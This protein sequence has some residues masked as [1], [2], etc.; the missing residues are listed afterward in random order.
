MSYRN[1]S[2]I[3]KSRLAPPISILV[4]AHNEATSIVSSVK[5]LLRLN[6]PAFEVIVVNDGSRD[7][8]L[9]KLIAVFELRKTKR[10]YHQT[11]ATKEVRGI[12]VAKLSSPW[13]RLVVLDK[14]NGGKADALN[15]GINVSEY[16]L[17]CS[18]DADSILERDSLLRVALPFMERAD[19]VG[20][21]GIVR[22]ANG[23]SITQGFVQTV[24]LP[25]QWLP[26]FQA[27]EYLRAFL[28]GRI[29]WA[30]LGS[31]L[32]LSGAFSLFKKAT[33]LEVNGYDRSTVSED[34]ELVMRLHRTLG[35]QGRACYIEFIPDPVCWTE[36]PERFK[37]LWR[38]RDRWQRGS[39][40]SLWKHLP[41]LCNPRFGIL[42]LLATPYF[43][44]VEF[45]S[46]VV[47][48]LGYLVFSIAAIAGLSQWK[49]F[50]AFFLLA[51]MMGVNLSLLAVVLE[52]F[53]LHRYPRVRDL[54]RLLISAV[55]ENFGYRQFTA[56]ARFA[57]ILGF[58]RG[59]TVW[60]VLE[61]RGLETTA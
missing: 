3:S 9:Q 54:L 15:A 27:V 56:L 8:T 41:L 10:I 30:N 4:P 34:M 7:E 23:C 24:R 53:T 42:G 17:F 37:M 19:V 50:A 28:S 48:V 31:L 25:K 26:C 39:G 49:A 59:R 52:E 58:L 21:G 5:A 40:Q 29:A 32:V 33:V 55:C 1:L 18:V 45:L 6:Y 51:V 14:E 46:P 60:G 38:Q 22:I 43:W 11:I 61:R 47:E 36:A 13:A 57:G 12:Y 16:P 44:A 2:E 35:D 20:V